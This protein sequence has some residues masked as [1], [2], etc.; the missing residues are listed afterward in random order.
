MKK[1][2]WILK[3]LLTGA[4]VVVGI[5]I[6]TFIILKVVTRHN[7]ELIVPELS[8]MTVPEALSV[9]RK[10]DLRLEI[11]D[12]VFIPR[13]GSGVVFRQHPIA[14]SSVKKNRR[15]LLTINSIEP[16]K[17]VVPSV[18]G[19]SLRQAKT[20]LTARQLKV[21]KLI[22]VEDIATNNVLSQLYLGREIPAG[23]QI[24]AESEIDLRVGMSSRNNRTSIPSLTGYSLITAKDILIDNSL[25]I[26]RL[27]YDNSVISY[28]DTLSSFV[29]K[30]M[31]YRTDSLSYPLGSRV[32]LMLSID[33][34]KLEEAK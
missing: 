18:T 29:I 16:K 8:G 3:N 21:G 4:A 25:N 27:T 33:K 26:G 12:S 28:T 20:E 2:R 13:M 1:D 19:F 31:P 17:V 22:Y 9:A 23:T 24:V 30:Q 10:S 5:L 11:S 14:G 6:L 15:I 7:V 32:D 34:S